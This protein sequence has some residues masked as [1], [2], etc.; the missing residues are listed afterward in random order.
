MGI[1]YDIN[2][3]DEMHSYCIT[4]VTAMALYAV[5]LRENK[6]RDAMPID[7]AERDKLAFMDLT[8]KENPY[9]RYVL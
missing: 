4:I 5:L 8:D 7:E 2:G 9:F 3:A 6:E 1:C